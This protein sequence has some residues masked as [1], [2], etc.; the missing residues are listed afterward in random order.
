VEQLARTDS[1]SKRSFDLGRSSGSGV[2][3]FQDNHRASRLLARGDCVVVVPTGSQGAIN[4]RV[5][6]EGAPDLVM[7][8][9]GRMRDLLVF[10]SSDLGQGFYLSTRR[11]AV[12]FYQLERDSFYPGRTMAGLG[13]YVLFRVLGPAR[14]V[15]LAVDVTRSL[16]HDGVNRLPPAAVVGAS[17]TR[18]DLVGRGSARVISPPIR[19]QVIGG[20]PYILLDMGEEGRILHVDRAGLAG[21]YNRSVV[22]DTRYLTSYV[23]DMS[24]VGDDA[25]RTLQAPSA[26]REFPA[27]LADPDLEYSGIYEDGWVGEESYA[28]LSGGG[29]TRLVVRADVREGTSPQRLRI[30]VDGRQVF[31]RAVRPG[32]VDVS[33]PLPA[34]PARRKVAL[35]FA[36]STPLPAPDSRPVAARLALLG[37]DG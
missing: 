36:R 20:Q 35:H 34:A 18:F 22:N 19:P 10:T 30:T 1:W 8:R 12:S 2:N 13:R 11:Q 17:R 5:L 26:L 3:T 29:P 25:Y 15:R 27:D 32:A 24:L 21:L 28:F 33:V 9:C 4:R 7:R 6:P 16:R 31:S 14:R 23:R 37:L